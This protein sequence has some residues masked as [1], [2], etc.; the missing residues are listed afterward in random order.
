M[1]VVG[2]ALTVNPDALCA[3]LHL[4]MLKTRTDCFTNVTV[5]SRS[6]TDIFIRHD[7]GIANIKLENLAPETL[8]RLNGEGSPGGAPASAKP[9]VAGQD[10]GSAAT[11]AATTV[12]A[13]ASHLDAQLRQQMTNSLT[14]L[15]TFSPV[16]VSPTV[17][18][19]VLGL[20]L[21]AYLFLCYCLKLICEKTG[22]KAGILI[23]LPILQI[24]PLLRAASMSRWWFLGLF[25][26]VVNL[27]AQ[28]VWCFKIV[29]ARGKSV[30]AAIGL[31]LPVTNLVALLYLAFSG[32][33][34]HEGPS[35]S[36]RFA[37]AGAPLPVDP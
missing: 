23:W 27:I 10:E 1:I 21:A 2:L 28:I 20:A 29:Q 26:P 36:R 35:V 24:F 9:E 16:P 3:D 34:R 12:P 37:L 17:V 15:K 32:D 7:R 14:A 30:W 5:C 22:N 11:Q 33:N 8:A 6:K 4:D 25:V 19:V 31:L 13:F 18:A